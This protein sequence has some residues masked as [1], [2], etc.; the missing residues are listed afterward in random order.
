MSV[1]TT[2]EYKQSVLWH[3]LEGCSIL[4][5]LCEKVFPDVE[6]ISMFYPLFRVNSPLVTLELYISVGELR[7]R[8]LVKKDGTLAA[9][10]L[11][12]LFYGYAH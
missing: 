4:P 12:K 7:L 11:E 9:N 8:T 2:F 3:F 6:S 1:C 5:I 10:L